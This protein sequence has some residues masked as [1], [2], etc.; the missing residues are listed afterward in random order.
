ME[1][2][3]PFLVILFVAPIAFW[4]QKKSVLFRAYFAAI[5]SATLAAITLFYVEAISLRSMFIPILLFFYAVHLFY[6]NNAKKV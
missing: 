4:I 6:G 3:L 2:L 1:S 5:A